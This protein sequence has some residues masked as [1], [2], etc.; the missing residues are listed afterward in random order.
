M[1]L[2]RV[3]LLL[4]LV[5]SVGLFAAY[6]ITGQIRYRRVGLRMLLTAIGAGFVFFAVLIIQRLV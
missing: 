1:A 5:A 3:V 4:M 6:A 2:F